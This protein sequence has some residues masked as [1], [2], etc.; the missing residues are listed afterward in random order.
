MSYGSSYRVSVEP[1]ENGFK[2]EVPDQE[3]IDKK[4]ADAKKNAK[5][6]CCP[7][8]YI[9]DCTKCY[10]AKNIAEVVKLVTAALKSIPEQEYDDAFEAA[11]EKSAGGMAH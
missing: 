2:V 8:P 9:G 4:R 10:A 11:S 6:G 3:A 7:D 5:N 1:L